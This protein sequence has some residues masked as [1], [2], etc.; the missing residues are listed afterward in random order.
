MPVLFHPPTQ[1]TSLT[2]KNSRAHSHPHHPY[3]RLAE[4]PSNHTIL[5]S[6][7]ECVGFPVVTTCVVP[8]P[9]P[10]DDEQRFFLPFPSRDA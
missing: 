10:D 2:S 1:S 4:K 9:D 3:L 5:F 8:I 6:F 7:S